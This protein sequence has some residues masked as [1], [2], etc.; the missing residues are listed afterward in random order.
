MTEPH[1]PFKR[2]R[3]E[4]LPVKLALYGP[5]KSGK[6]Y[7]A[8]MIARGVAG[9]DGRIAVLDTEGGS[10]RMYAD[11]VPGGYSVLAM[12]A[13]YTPQRFVQ[14]IATAIEHGYDCLIID[15]VSQAWEGA[16]G[17][18][19]IVDRASTGSNKNKW[20]GWAVGTPEHQRLVAAIAACPIHLVATM[21]VKTEWVV[22]ADNK[23]EKVGLKPVQRDGFEYEFTFVG[24]VDRSHD[25][26]FEARGSFDGIRLPAIGTTD[27]M[28]DDRMAETR[29]QLIKFGEEI[30][31]WLD[32]P[33]TIDQLD[34]ESAS[35]PTGD[36]VPD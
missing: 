16:G 6:T 29:A 13:P 18:Q 11:D 20:A 15:G 26:V 19:E 23:P 14:G 22:G 9:S 34:L 2:A 27:A 31:A 12:G 33:D 8:L 32:V 25:I 24:L 30:A 21:R 1:D 28:G 3:R 4:R 17:V 5:S 10:S 35:L 36:V 7:S